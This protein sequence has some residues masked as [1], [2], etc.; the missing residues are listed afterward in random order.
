MFLCKGI[1]TLYYHGR[2]FYNVNNLPDDFDKNKDMYIDC[3]CQYAKIK[4][5]E[6]ILK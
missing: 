3:D 1:D 2:I 4:R 5:F 6:K